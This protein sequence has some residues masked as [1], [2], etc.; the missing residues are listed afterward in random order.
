MGVAMG[1][2]SI[3]DLVARVTAG[4]PVDFDQVIAAIDTHYH[5]QPCRF[6]NGVGRDALVNERGTNEGSCKIFFFARLLGFD[7]A[8]TL[9]LFGD[10]YRQDVLKNPGG[11]NHANIRRFARDGWPGII[12]EGVALVPRAPDNEG[13]A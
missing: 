2:M 11:T 4:V 8:Q 7:E 6:R 13:R 1:A 10:Y 9:A 5:Y 3:E 12:H